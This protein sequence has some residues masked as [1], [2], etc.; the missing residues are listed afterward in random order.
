MSMEAHLVELKKRHSVLEQQIA[1][2]AAHPSADT[3][4]IVKL[5]RK[6]LTLK[7]QIKRMS[8]KRVEH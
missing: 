6:K 1:A 5:K 4:E 7:D 3:L 8:I 2:V